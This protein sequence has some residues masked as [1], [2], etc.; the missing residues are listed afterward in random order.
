MYI[1]INLKIFL[2]IKNQKK[3]SCGSIIFA[4][5]KGL[6]GTLLSKEDSSI[7][8]EKKSKEDS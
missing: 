8:K 5:F 6:I 7:K 2:I 1:K 3:K 4:K